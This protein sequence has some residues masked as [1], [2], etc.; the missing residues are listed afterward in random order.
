MY[1]E[2]STLPLQVLVYADGERA[3]EYADPEI[4]SKQ[5][6]KDSCYIESTL[7]GGFWVQLRLDDDETVKWTDVGWRLDFHL[8]I[9]DTMPDHVKFPITAETIDERILGW[10][11]VFHEAVGTGDSDNTASCFRFAFFRMYKVSMLTLVG[12][13]LINAGLFGHRRIRKVVQD[14]FSHL[15]RNAGYW[16]YY[17][18][19]RMGGQ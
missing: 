13:L 4:A 19:P 2:K 17:E 5:H 7:N 16:S 18:H 12:K 8:S 14:L 9:N 3:E 11:F 6:N 15:H 1:I 10:D